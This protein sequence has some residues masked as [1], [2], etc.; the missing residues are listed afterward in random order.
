MPMLFQAVMRARRRS[1]RRWSRLITAFL[2]LAF[3][4]SHALGLEIT[5]AR[6]NDGHNL[7]ACATSPQTPQPM[8]LSRTVATGSLRKGSGLGWMVS[9]GHPER[10]M[11]EW[12]PV[13]VS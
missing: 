8:Q 5:S 12:S 3:M 13:H 1:I 11:Q 6:K 2:N 9:D 4:L 7:A 10:R